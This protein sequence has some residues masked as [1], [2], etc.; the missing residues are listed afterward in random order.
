M[1]AKIM[2]GT[3]PLIQPS[4]HLV[5][6]DLHF[7]YIAHPLSHLTFLFETTMLYMHSFYLMK[8]TQNNHTHTTGSNSLH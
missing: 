7:L 8:N 1:Y 4:H 2:V 3:Q 5:N 6:F